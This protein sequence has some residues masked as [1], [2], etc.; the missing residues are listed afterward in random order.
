MTEI[1]RLSVNLAPGVAAV[2]K[3]NALIDGR[4]VTE[5]IRHAIAVHNLVVETQR[6]G[7]TVIV[8]DRD[9]GEREVVLL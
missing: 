9:G 6:A 5:E 7:G 1:V 2:L 8:R 3:R 4:S